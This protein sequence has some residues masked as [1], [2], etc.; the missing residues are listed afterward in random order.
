MSEKGSQAVNEMDLFHGTRQVN[1]QS[2]YN[3]EEGFDMRFSS[4]GAWGTGCYFAVNASYSAMYS[5]PL[6]NGLFQ[7]FLAKVLTGDSAQIASDPGLRMP[8][9]KKKGQR[10]FGQTRFDTVTGISGDSQIFVT[11]KN[12][13]AYP[14][15]LITFTL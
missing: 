3:S 2:I 9:L 5:H 11:Y 12:D 13:K 14:F 15:Y 4:P 10:M 7:M 8:P 1:P 6:P